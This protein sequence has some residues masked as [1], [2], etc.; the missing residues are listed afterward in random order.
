MRIAL[1]HRRFTTHGGTERFIVGLTRFLLQNGHEVHVYCNEVRKG[2]RK[3]FPEVTFHYLPMVKLG[4]F[5]KVL[6]FCFSAHVFVPR[7]QF[8]IVQGFGW[9]LSQDIIRIGGGSFFVQY[10]LLLSEA[11]LLKRFLL[12][13]SLRH[14]FTLWM[15]RVQMRS[16]NCRAVIAVSKRVSDELITQLKVDPTRVRVVYN[17]VDL[18]QF[19]L[20]N[21]KHFR[22]ALRRTYGLAEESQVVLF[23]GTG[24]RRKGLHVAIRAFS[25]VA[26]GN[27]Y[28]IVVGKDGAEGRYRRLARSLNTLG[29]V[30]FCGPTEEPERYY[31]A[32]DLF[33]FPTRYE[34]F[35]NVCLEAM[36]SGLPV[37]TSAVNGVS[38]I[39]PKEARDL[40]L[41]D[42]KD[43]KGLAFR[44]EQILSNPE[45]SDHLGKACRLAAEQMTLEATGRHIQAIYQKVLAEKKER[46]YEGA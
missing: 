11:G 43:V 31:A 10:K 30:I 38:E 26:T 19:H 15:E 44:M 46:V 40:V 32:A 9:T 7:H 4:V 5:L 16:P 17:G 21:R 39:F 18:K 41:P 20:D 45:L 23:L 25:M 27:R 22:A 2:L 28:M 6:S 12:K 33:V 13:L 1:V 34:P 3:S 29:H 42:A 8:D 36:A 35:G 24:Y 14:R 37:I